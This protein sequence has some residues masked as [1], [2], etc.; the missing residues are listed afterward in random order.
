MAKKRPTQRT[1]DYIREHY[2]DAFIDKVERWIASEK[3]PGGGVRKDLFG[4]I[5]LVA[6]REGKIVGIQCSGYTA[7][8]KHVDKIEEAPEAM[9]WLLAGGIL[10]VWGFKKT[11]IGKQI[12]YLPKV[13]PV[14][15]PQ[16][17]TNPEKPKP[18]TELFV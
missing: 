6:I 18:V 2:P 16:I 1:L 10:E 5:D 9:A 4:I 15:I 13:V 11:R 17:P 7:I 14:T 8:K 12:R 3:L